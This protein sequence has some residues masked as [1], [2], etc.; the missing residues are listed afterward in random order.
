MERVAAES[1]NGCFVACVATLTGSTYSEAFK[2]IHPNSFRTPY[3]GELPTDKVKKLL[4]DLGWK[5][6]VVRAKHI[7]SLKKDALI[8]IQWNNAPGLAHAAVYDAKH[9]Q[10]IDPTFYPPLRPRTYEKQLHSILYIEKIPIK[11][12]ETMSEQGKSDGKR[13]VEHLKEAERQLKTA[14]EYTKKAGDKE[15]T[16]KIEKSATEV[17]TTREGLDKKLSGPQKN[18]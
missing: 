5:I 15:T 11:G 7:A 9:R 8:I 16:Q 10:I 18:G 3:N 1:E 14:V 17:S 12:E 2:L 13:A 6:R 4:R